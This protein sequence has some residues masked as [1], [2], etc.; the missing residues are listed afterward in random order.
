MLRFEITV[1]NPDEYIVI[2]FDAEVEIAV[3]EYHGITTVPSQAMVLDKTGSYVFVYD[4]EE[5]RNKN[6]Y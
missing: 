3:G 2:G 6:S 1:D 5:N 4:E